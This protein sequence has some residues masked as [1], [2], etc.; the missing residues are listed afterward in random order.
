MILTNEQILGLHRHIGYGPIDKAHFIFFGNEPGINIS[1]GIENSI[2]SLMEKYKTRKL[3][4]IGQ[5]F[6]V[7]E[8]DDPP[9]SSTFLQFIS[10]FMLAL[11]YKD[12]RFF[13]SLSKEG[14][15]FLNNYIINELNRTETALINLRPFP[16]STERNWHY[17]N[18]V[19]QEYQ[20]L[21]NFTLISSHDNIY[22]TI[23]LSI[24]NKAFEMVKN[25]FIIGIG[26]KDN[27]RT[28]LNLMYPEIKFSEILLDGNLK[29]YFSK[30]PNIIL[31][32]YWDTRNIGLSGLKQIYN[33]I[34][35]LSFL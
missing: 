31:S 4:T 17:S 3:L 28:F 24:M 21:F 34:N 27:K 32:N 20:K 16:Q 30:K 23:R 26:D 19:E 12:D 18:V 15:S 5:G 2:H 29:I 1:K 8:I 11:R 22:K 6:S 10:R 35:S 7:L 14:I 13:E 9:V 25:S 33:F